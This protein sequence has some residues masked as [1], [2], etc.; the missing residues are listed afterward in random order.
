MLHSYFLSVSALGAVSLAVLLYAVGGEAERPRELGQ[1]R[2]SERLSDRLS[3]QYRAQMTLAQEALRRSGYAPGPVDGLMDFETASAL[4][5][6]QRDHAL[7]VTGRATPE[8]L[9]ALGIEDRLRLPR[10]TR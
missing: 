8:T 3:A 1:A 4:R 7:R 2:P 9:A 6:F 5:D 10:P